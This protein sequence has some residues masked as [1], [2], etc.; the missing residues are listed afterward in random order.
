VEPVEINAGD[1]YLRMLR[2]DERVD[3]RPAV[4]AAFGDPETAR[5]IPEYRVRTIDEATSYIV[6]RERE[7][8]QDRRCSWAVAEPTTGAMLGEVGLKNLDLERGAAAIACWTHP[9]HRGRGIAAHAVSAAL[10]FGFGALGL[11][12]V[13]YWH[14]EGNGA[15]ARVAVKCGFRPVVRVPGGTQVDGEQ[16]D[17]HCYAVLG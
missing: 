14:A 2:A 8:A 9:A 6:Q 15:S 5:W 16:R 11:T 13:E 7:W 4:L 17:L 10:R 1:Y 3:D 12:R